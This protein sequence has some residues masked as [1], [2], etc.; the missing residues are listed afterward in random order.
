MASSVIASPKDYGRGRARP[1]RDQSSGLIGE[2]PKP[3]DR[4]S[5]WEEAS[6]RL[7]HVHRSSH[8]DRSLLAA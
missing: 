7:R 4:R 8:S 1:A 3:A 6:D 5:S 2:Y